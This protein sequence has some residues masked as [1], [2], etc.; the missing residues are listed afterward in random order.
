MVIPFYY[1]VKCHLA[2]IRLRPKMTSKSVTLNKMATINENKVYIY[3]FFLKL[4]ALYTLTTV[5]TI[6]E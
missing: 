1:Q 4:E 2:P 3:F 5:S 6:P